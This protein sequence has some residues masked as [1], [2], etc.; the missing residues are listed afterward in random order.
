MGIFVVNGPLKVTDDITVGGDIIDLGNAKITTLTSNADVL[1]E[2]NGTGKVKIG[3]LT[4]PA[5]AD[6]E[7][8]EVLTLGAGG[9][10]E[11]A[12]NSTTV[13]VSRLGSN[14]TAASGTTVETHFAGVDTELGLIDGRLTTAETTL[15]SKLAAVSED[16]DPSL[17]GDLDVNGYSLV[18]TVTNSNIVLV[19]D[20]T[21]MI[22][23][24][25][26]FY[27]KK[28]AV[29][30]PNA[31]ATTV[32]TYPAAGND[33]VFIDYIVRRGGEGTKFGTLM[34]AHDGTTHDLIDT[35]GETGAPGVTFSVALATGTITLTGTLTDDT[36][37]TQAGTMAYSMRRWGVPV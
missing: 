6:G 30:L 3:S 35:G 36:D 27:S 10:L 2:A 15:G 7:T 12:S 13:F 17:G 1:I 8:G 21:G 5:A 16:E 23:F 28:Q 22:E 37:G 29:T 24:G 9:V 4:M 25:G 26:V 31:A 32:T 33:I 18:T 11:W 20:G 34:I 14:Y 19:P